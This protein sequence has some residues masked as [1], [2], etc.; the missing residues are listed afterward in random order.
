METALNKHR[1]AGSKAWGSHA[2]LLVGTKLLSLYSHPTAPSLQ[3]CDLFLLGLFVQ[4]VLDRKDVPGLDVPEPPSV[5][6]MTALTVPRSPESPGDGSTSPVTGVSGDGAPSDVVSD[7][8]KVTETEA[9]G[10]R[11]VPVVGRDS[12]AGSNSSLAEPFFAARE[13]PATGDD[14]GLEVPT[15]K[16]DSGSG[17]ESGS[18]NR[19]SPFFDAESGGELGS[20][21]ATSRLAP[22]VEVEVELRELRREAVFLHTPN[23]NYAPCVAPPTDP[24]SKEFAGRLRLSV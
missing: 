5:P 7:I 1:V 12:R 24:P 18:V 15:D 19:D 10:L 11:A 9:A 17:T 6:A 22:S 8:I 2:M 23:N 4:D 21:T 16:D 3:T 20:A 13:P 14:H